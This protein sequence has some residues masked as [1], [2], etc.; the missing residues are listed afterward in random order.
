MTE[1][2]DS[3]NSMAKKA[4]KWVARVRKTADDANLELSEWE[5]EFLTS[6]DARLEK[7]GRAFADPDLGAMDAPLSLRQGLKVKEIGKK[8]KPK[9]ISNVNKP[10]KPR[11]TLKTNKPLLS[12]TGFK[13]KFPRPKV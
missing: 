8:A 4:R 9:A 11:K 7:Y 6:I 12:K 10:Q 5:Y 1:K 2:S 3:D 13:R